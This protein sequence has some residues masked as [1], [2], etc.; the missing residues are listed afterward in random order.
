MYK[1]ILLPIDGSTGS[2]YAISE[3]ATLAQMSGASIHLLHV[4]DMAAYTSGFELPEVYATYTRPL[5]LQDGNALLAKVRT[6]LEANGARVETELV[7][8]SGE[9]V[10]TIITSHATACHADIIVLGTH[11]RRGMGRMLIGSDAEQVAR[12]SPVPVMLVRAP[13]T[14]A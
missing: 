14:P 5:A 8:S 3:A 1:T 7:E 12:T 13:S 6:Q 11:G 2:S 4:I 9:R 10:A